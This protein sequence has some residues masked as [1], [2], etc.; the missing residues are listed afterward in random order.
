MIHLY[1]EISVNFMHQFFFQKSNLV[2]PFG[3]YETT[4][5]SK[6]TTRFWQLSAR[7]D[8]VKA[9]SWTPARNMLGD[10]SLRAPIFRVSYKGDLWRNP[11]DK[12]IRNTAENQ[13]KKFKSVSAV[14]FLSGHVGSLSSWRGRLSFHALLLSSGDYLQAVV[15]NNPLGS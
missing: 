1:L 5:G 4:S 6:G 9:D 11:A 15:V 10:E 8:E 2:P 12:H 13:G 3:N 7:R 14:F